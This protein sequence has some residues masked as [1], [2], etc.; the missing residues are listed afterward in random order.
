MSL[1]TVPFGETA[2]FNVI[3]EV[4]TGGQKKYAYD[5][6]MEAFKLSN[7]LYDE[8]KFPFNYGYVAQTLADDGNNLDAYVLSTHSLSRGTVVPCRAV[9]MLE[10]VDRE[11]ND[12]KILAVPLSE[13]R[14]EYIKDLVDMPKE[15]IAAFEEFYKHLAKQWG[16]DIR[17]VRFSDK[18][19]AKKELLRTMVLE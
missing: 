12:N 19:Q 10:V 3:V 8:A 13:K 5:H 17:I 15:Y 16:G 11:Q 9:G 18:E 6:D 7:V 14:L 4:P 2:A 1:A